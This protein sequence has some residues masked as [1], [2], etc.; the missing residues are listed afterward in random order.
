MEGH[1]E[2]P[3]NSLPSAGMDPLSRDRSSPPF[4]YWPE[5]TWFHF[6]LF[7]E[8]NWWICVPVL[9]GGIAPAYQGKFALALPHAAEE[10]CVRNAGDPSGS[11][12]VTLRLWLMENYNNPM[13]AGFLM[14]LRLQQWRFG[15][16]YRV[17]NPDDLGARWRQREHRVNGWRTYNQVTS[18]R[19]EDRG[20]LS[21]CSLF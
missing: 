21:V 8:I 11:L 9:A 5:S 4:F 3:A 1:V 10:A 15:S 2:L 20:V 17:M 19:N 7:F 18:D 6:I 13:H 12:S 14:A 16:S